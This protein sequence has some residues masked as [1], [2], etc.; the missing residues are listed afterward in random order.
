ML[1]KQDDRELIDRFLG[2]KLSGMELEQFHL[3]MQRDEDFSNE[4]RFQQLLRSGIRMAKE[5]E[6]RKK[7]LVAIRYRKTKIPYGLKLIFTFFIFSTI[8]ICGTGYCHRTCIGA[9]R[10]V[11]GATRYK[12]QLDTTR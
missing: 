5:E 12:D 8:I 2:E 9:G 11:Y 4:I 10:C 7:V 1:P 6:M 3:R